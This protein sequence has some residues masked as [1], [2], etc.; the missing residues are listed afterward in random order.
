LKKIVVIPTYNESENIALVVGGVLDIDPE[1][2]VLVVDDN[3]PDG[4]G[5]IA[6]G[7]ADEQRRVNVLHRR[8]KEGLGPAYKEGFKKA[9]AM[10][11]QRVVQMDADLSHPVEDLPRL[12]QAID[13]GCDLV[14][15]SRY[16]EG[17]TVVNWPMGRLLLSYLGN[18][19]ARVLL[20][21]VPVKDATGGFKCWRREALEAIDLEGVAS[22]GYVF[23][24]EMNYRAWLKGLRL[25][26]IPI[27]FVDRRRGRSKMNLGIALEALFS[28][29]RLRLWGMTGRLGAADSRSRHA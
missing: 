10:G 14:L 18:L 3:S 24:V 19:Y 11:A 6:E 7:L 17:I 16:V 15:G 9:L 26:E 13:D 27:I 12:Y 1:N 20:G 29:L 21:G 22:N 5:R 2:E 4:T 23:Q 8:R 28:V 25:R